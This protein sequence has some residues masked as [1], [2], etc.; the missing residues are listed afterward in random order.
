M[1]HDELLE[2]HRITV[3]FS[4]THGAKRLGTGHGTG[5]HCRLSSYRSVSHTARQARCGS[6]AYQHGAQRSRRGA[7]RVRLGWGCREEW[8]G[9]ILLLPALKP[10]R[11]AETVLVSWRR[12]RLRGSSCSLRPAGPARTVCSSSAAVA[13]ASSS[14]SSSSP[15]PDLATLPRQRHSRLGA[16]SRASPA[17]T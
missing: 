12:R 1:R 3:E 10:I 4:F 17:G 6:I 9:P 15:P 7:R 2:T 8:V 14:A 16:Y 5:E 13:V 11:C